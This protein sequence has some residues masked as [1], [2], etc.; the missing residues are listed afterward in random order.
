[1]RWAA[2][3]FCLLAAPLLAA[4]APAPGVGPAVVLD[5]MDD[6]AAW[7]ATASDGVSAGHAPVQDAGVESTKALRLAW[8]FHSVSGFALVRRLLPLDL[9]ENYQLS[10]RI[11]WTGGINDFQL[12]LIDATGD[13]VW[14]I[15]RPDINLKLGWQTLSFRKRDIAFAWGPGKDH[16]LRRAAAV[17]F[18]INRG[19]DGG[20]GTLDIDDFTLTPLPVTPQALPA[21]RL[22]AP[23]GDAAAAMDGRADTAWTGQGPLLIDFGGLREFGGLV[24]YWRGRPAPYSIETSVDEVVWERR[25]QVRASSGTGDP[26]ALPQTEARWLRIVPDAQSSL[27]E[28]DIKPREWAATPNDFIATL[29]QQAPRGSYPRG[30]SG[31][32]SY[33]TLFGTDGGGTQALISEDG[34]IESAKGSFSVEPFVV[35]GGQRFGWSDVAV[36]HGLTEGYLPMP[37]VRWQSPN[38]ELTVKT[39]ADPGEAGRVLVRYTLVNT[40]ARPL[41][42][43]L[44]LAARPFQV[45]PPAQFLSQ[46]GGVS[47]IV[48]LRTAGTGVDV[49]GEADP[50]DGRPRI[51]HLRTDKAPAR[52][53]L[54][55]FDQAQARPDFD[56]AGTD[57]AVSAGNTPTVADET[58]LASALLAFPLD[59]A[60][61]GTGTVLLAIAPEGG[62]VAIDADKFS[63]AERASADYWRTRLNGVRIHVPAAH[64]R[65]VDTLRTALAHIL[66]SREGPILRPGTRSYARSWIRDGA[67]IGEGLLRLGQDAPVQA[68]ADWY[69]T[70]LFAN[71]KVPCCVD[72]RGADP[73]PENDSQGEYIFLVTQLYRFT[74]D[75]TLLARHWPA[76]AAAERYMESL[77]ASTRIPANTSADTA[78]LYGLMPPSISHEG[79]SAKPQYSLWDDFWTLRGYKD[80]AY[81][82]EV[83]GEPMAAEID[84]HRDQFASDLHAAVAAAATHWRIDYIPGATSLGDFDATSTTVALDPA[85][86]EARLDPRLLAGTFDRYW[87]D[88]L[89]RRAGAHDWKDYT[90]YELRTLSAMVRLGHR[91]RIDPML[92]FFFADQRPQGWNGWAEV[93]GRNP[94]EI[95]FLG[96][97]PHAWVA[98]DFIRSVLDIFAYEREHDRTIVLGAGLSD[99]WL[100]GRGI[101]VHGLRSAYGAL[102]F[103]MRATPKSLRVR[104]SADAQPPGGYVVPWPWTPPP[105]PATLNGRPIRLENGAFR[106]PAAK[107]PLTLEVRR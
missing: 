86:E 51:T 79:Y 69:R 1:M 20:A 62:T 54:A 34:A 29:A 25:R 83:L 93:V 15:S 55:S 88:F 31:E 24:L 52:T 60:A 80:A 40:G 85:G 22:S 91:Q 7:T 96:D 28:I 56:A 4:A 14:W 19:R 6:T 92:D 41:A 103:T 95:R 33:W 71:G 16:V 53:I 32:Q 35:L 47:P 50:R 106:L 63:T 101:D 87:R 72:F 5:T 9:P 43:H 26:I 64:Q 39:F 3:L 90:P 84:R 44:L 61:H 98:S 58:G 8:D 73:V 57:G 100:N 70:H 48:A 30:F 45:N 11:R 99:S 67:M 76:I 78:M 66:I 82:A 102:D 13:N 104:I 38:W 2:H 37:W 75:R 65:L 23:E 94:R 17:E 46:R 36:S 42:A 97:L 77:R 27:T 107:I 105:G 89:R 21:P 18:V 81:V 59:L 74:G 49:V 10:F 12:K 68:Y